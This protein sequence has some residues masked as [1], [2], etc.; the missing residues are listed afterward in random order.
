MDRRILQNIFDVSLRT[1]T[2]SR[3]KFLNAQGYGNSSTQSP[4]Q[5]TLPFTGPVE[6]LGTAG[7]CPNHFFQKC[8][9]HLIPSFGEN[10]VL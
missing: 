2:F 1:P 4:E 6:H 5:W 8:L 3:E 10:N 7:I 9:H